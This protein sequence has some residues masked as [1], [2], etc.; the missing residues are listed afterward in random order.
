MGHR[1][2]RQGGD[3]QVV[4]QDRPA[5]DEGDQLVECV[6][7]KARGAA[8]L[9][10]HRP[11]LDVAERGDDEEEAGGEEDQR[12]QAET[13]IGD[14]TEREVDREAD[15]RVDGNEEPWHARGTLKQ[16]LQPWFR[17]LLSLLGL[18]HVRDAIQSRPTPTA[19]NAI[20]SSTPIES[21]PPPAAMVLTRSARPSR[22][23]TSEKRRT[24]PR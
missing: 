15:R 10:Q 19:R 12:R 3:D 7:G 20:P 6:A 17:V 16:R 9:T 14:D 22:T 18:A 11:A 13:T 4:D 1:N 21:G 2:R 23:K 8:P 24:E 5:G